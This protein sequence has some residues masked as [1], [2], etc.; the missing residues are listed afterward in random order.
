MLYI[1]PEFQNFPET[2]LFFNLRGFESRNPLVGR[3]FSF[4]NKRYGKPRCCKAVARPL[5][6]IP[7]VTDPGHHPVFPWPGKPHR[8]K[9]SFIRNK[10]QC[11][12]VIITSIGSAFL[13]YNHWLMYNTQMPDFGLLGVELLL[14][15]CRGNLMASAYAHFSSV[16]LVFLLSILIL[17]LV[18]SILSSLSCFYLQ[19]LIDLWGGF[20][21]QQGSL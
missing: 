8:F 15:H 4:S 21:Y 20:V 2:H 3:E 1:F 18:V 6:W 10:C 11:W 16:L 9:S 17:S 5:Y 7:Q 14:Y 19:S 12:P 13:S